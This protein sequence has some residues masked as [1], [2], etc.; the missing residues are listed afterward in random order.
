MLDMGFFDDVTKI[1]DL[2]KNKRNLGM[3]SATISQEVMTVSW[4]YQRDEVEITVPADEQNKPDITQY[5]VTVPALQK[6]EA[7]LRRHGGQRLRARDYLLQHQAHVPAAG[8]RFAGA[9]LHRRL[10]PRRHPAG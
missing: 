10:H 2:I 4:M 7:V 1:L 9:E 5:A 6:L 8:G 3:F